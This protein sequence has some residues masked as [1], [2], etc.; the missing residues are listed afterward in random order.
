[1]QAQ[2]V[3][4]YKVIQVHDV[5]ERAYGRPSWELQR[6][7][8]DELIL[9]VLSQHT[10]DGNSG[11]AFGNLVQEFGSWP[12]VMAASPAEI[13]VPIVVGG[14]A[15][16]KSLRIKRIL[17]VIQERTGDLDLGFLRE[18]P[19]DSAKQWLESLPGVGPKTAACVLLFACKRPAI[20]VDTHVHR[21]SL[22]LG[23]VDLR[24]SAEKTQRF[25]ERVVPQEHMHSLHVNLIQHGRKTCRASRPDCSHCPL[26]HLCDYYIRKGATS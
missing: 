24:T 12:A 16:V 6:D 7:P 10:S 8:L 13:A 11:R 5:L 1:V 23:L 9:T 21:V 15:R 25:L 19:S 20:P 22:R 18:M 2:T 26:T 14:L 4:S 3:G 17:E